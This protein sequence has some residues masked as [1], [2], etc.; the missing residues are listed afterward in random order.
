MLRYAYH[1]ERFQDEGEERL[2]RLHH[3]RHFRHFRHFHHLHRWFKL[4]IRSYLE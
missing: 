2:E 1:R 3:F 4:S